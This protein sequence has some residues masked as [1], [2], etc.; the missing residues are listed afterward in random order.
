MKICNNEEDEEFS[1]RHQNSKLLSCLKTPRNMLMVSS[2][3]IV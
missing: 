3:M 2:A 1:Q